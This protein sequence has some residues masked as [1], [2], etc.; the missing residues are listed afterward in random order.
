[1]NKIFIENIKVA[2]KSIRSQALR[3]FLTI[4]II[5]I[6]I[7]ALVGI[8]TS[9]DAIKDKINSEFSSMGSNTFTVRNA[10]T[11]LRRGG[12]QRK[13]YPKITYKEAMDFAEA[14]EYPSVVSI[15]ANASMAATV[16]YDNDKTD[17]N[18]RVIGGD[19]NY[20]YTSG[21]QLDAGR[22]FNSADIELASNVVILG[23]D[24][25]K[26]I[27]PPGI[28]PI[29]KTIS[30]GSVRY[31]VIGTFKEKGNSFGFSGDNQCLVPISNVNKYYLGP[32]TTFTINVLTSDP[33]ELTSAISEAI[34]VF[35]V[36]RRDAIGKP[37]SFDVAKSDNLANILIS[38]ISTVTIIATVIGIITLFGAAIGLMNI[39]LVSVTERTREIGTRKA[40]GASSRTIRTQFLT[41]AIIIGQLGGFLGIILGI[42][43]GNLISL[44]IDGNFIIP[45]LWIIS[46]VILCFLV[47]VISGYYPA[48]KAA[49]L[50]PID[51]LRYE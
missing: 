14:Y 3:T 42:S 1:M 5:A 28:S 4:F 51:A 2:F 22:N 11:G 45:W 39:M 12:G 32:T 8:L 23:Q 40:L 30:I 50:D 44:I 15:T 16:K 31:K 33:K 27:F 9:I 17:P 38:E 47:G 29:D 21:Y 18:V 48:K 25:V 46:G 20:I 34:G 35:R 36:I 37:N 13:V 6:G 49:N 43:I 26:S 10:E 41:E 24:I 7:T 19:A